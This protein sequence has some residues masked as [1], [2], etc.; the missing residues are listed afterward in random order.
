MNETNCSICGDNLEKEYKFDEKA[1]YSCVVID[2][3]QPED[4]YWK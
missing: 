1:V 4:D 3:G 2:R